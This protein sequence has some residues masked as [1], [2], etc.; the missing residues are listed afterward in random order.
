MTHHT[1]SYLAIA[2]KV[3]ITVVGFG[4]LYV[5]LTISRRRNRIAQRKIDDSIVRRDLDPGE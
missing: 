3:G 2:F 4:V 5:L 1:M